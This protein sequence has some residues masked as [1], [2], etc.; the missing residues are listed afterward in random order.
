M[1]ERPR[2]R[3]DP[4]GAPSRRRAAARAALDGAR[5]DLVLVFASGAHLAAPEATL[6]GVREALEPDVLVGCGAGG[7]LGR[8]P[9]DRAR[10]RRS[11]SGRA[12][13][14]GGHRRRRSTRAVEERRGRRAVDGPARPRRRDAALIMLPDP[15][16]VPDRR[17]ARALADARAR[18]AGDRRAGQRAH[19]RRRGGAVPRRR[20]RRA[21]A[22]SASR[23]DGVEVL[24]CVS[25]GAAPIGP[26]ADDHR[27][28]G[29]VIR[30]LAGAGARPKL[31]EAIEGARPRTS[32]TLIGGGLLLG[33][34]V[35]GDKP[36][37]VQGDFL[38]R[39]VD[40]RRPRRR[41]DRG[42]RARAARP[43]RAPA[44]ARRRIG[45]PR[46]AR[47]RSALRREALGGAPPAGAL[48]FTC[49]GRGRGDV[50]RRRPRRRRRRRGARAAPRPRA[51]SPP[52]RSARSAARTS[53]TASPR[54]SRCSRLNACET[55]APWSWPAAAALV[56]GATGGIGQAIARALAAR[57]REARPHRAPRRRARAA[58]RRARRPGDR[59][60][61]RRP[62]RA[63]AAGRR[64]PATWT[65]SSPTR[66]CRLRASS[67]S[68]RGRAGRP[69]AG[70]QPARP[71]RARARL[72]PR[73]AER[74]RGH[75]VFISSLSGKVGDAGS[76][77]YSAT[78]FGLR[79][80]GQS[81]R[82]DLARQRRR[83]QRRSSPASSATPGCSTTPAWSCPAYVGTRSPEDVAAAVDARDRA[84]SRRGRRRAALGAGSA[85]S[86]ASSRPRA[87]R[88]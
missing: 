61:P 57:G 18:R 38:V 79:G 33:I 16:L 81:L 43:G 76:S 25:Q 55:A 37:Y 84:R 24:P 53:C 88:A 70:R 11:P 27:R 5:A 30:E 42:R 80:F 85:S 26:R 83:R 13:L 15:L 71:D 86:S 60:R 58:G 65:S 36:D 9:R 54:R 8:G 6:E 35:D 23:L 7:V 31:R 12:S 82:K 32:A 4:R 78:K 45:R 17:G 51:S 56:T 2:D 34:V 75:L 44:R 87:P 64:R 48:V 68:L 21:A 62:R 72:L 29:H 67:T 19:A 74:G 50:R 59:R 41:D 47:R 14:D 63:C 28:R 22:R 77:L 69:G 1:L 66:R 39:G 3:H 40:R 20:G 49:N 10:A 46:P 73:M 52:A